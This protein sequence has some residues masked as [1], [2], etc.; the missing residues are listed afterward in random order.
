[1]PPEMPPELPP[2]TTT[3]P[4]AGQ[5]L[6]LL[7]QGRPK[8]AAAVCEAVLARRPKDVQALHILGIL[9]AQSGDP[10]RGEALLRRAMAA[11]PRNP[12][13]P[14]DLGN[15]YLATNRVAEAEPCFRAAVELAPAMAEARLGLATALARLGRLDE[16]LPACH[17]ALKLKP[18]LAPTHNVLGNILKE[19]GRLDDATACYRRARSLAPRA[20]DPHFNLGLMARER[21]S[22][23]EAIA[24]YRAALTVAPRHAPSHYNLGIALLLS[25][26]YPAGWP[27]YEWRWAAKGK[28]PR[29]RDALWTGQNLTGKRIFIHSEQGLGDSLHMLRYLPAVA[30]RAASTVL[31]VPAPLLPLAAA[32][33]WPVELQAKSAPAPPFDLQC[34]MMSL[35]RAFGTTFE[36]IPAG[37]P[38]LKPPEARKRAWSERLCGLSGLKAGIV[39]AGNVNQAND[40]NRSL[41][42]ARLAPLL[43]L[44]GISWVSLQVGPKSAELASLPE[45]SV[46]DIS[47]ELTDFAETAAAAAN[48]DVIVSVDTSVGHL[49]GALALPTF[50][51][52]SF[53]ADWRWPTG[54]ADNPWYPSLTVFRQ[55]KLGDW[56]PVV[57]ATTDALTALRD[58]S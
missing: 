34:P 37:T 46:L 16:A 51:L 31:E 38:Y 40:G 35:P 10:A 56:D 36:T 47:P 15:L 13:A 20:V 44:P 58:S 22:F 7:R 6:N 1:M 30:A 26:D 5:A 24:H 57:T 8:E 28:Q 53:A 9:S 29:F 50:I 33:G 17:A 2:A 12:A 19:Q 54:R 27:E 45:G 39:W 49:A 4:D 11:D 25:G 14:Y 21:N 23:E 3:H 18:E 41:D 32:Q 42:L 52:L 48:L 55:E 43:A